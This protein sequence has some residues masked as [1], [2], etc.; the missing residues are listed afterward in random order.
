MFRRLLTGWE[1]RPARP[2]RAPGE[3]LRVVIELAGFDK[4]AEARWYLILPLPS[5]A[6]APRPSSLRRDMLDRFAPHL[7]MSHFS[8]TGYRL[9]ARR[10]IPNI[11]FI[12]NVGRSCA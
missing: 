8:D 6:T 11:T 1:G 3:P 2:A 4:G 10:G 7:A 12:H 9:F 5:T